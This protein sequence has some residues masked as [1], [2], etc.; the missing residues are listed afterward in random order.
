MLDRIIQSGLEDA[1]VYSDRG[2]VYRLERYDEALQSFGR[3]IELNAGLPH[4]YM[5]RAWTYLDQNEYD[6]AIVD[7]TAAAKLWVRPV[8]PYRCR[9]RCH[10]ALGRYVDAIADLKR[11]LPERS[12][13]ALELRGHGSDSAE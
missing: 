1:E 11:A 8:N 10:A 13:I 4:A 12:T 2:W 3:A 9:A 5:G 6:K 7:A